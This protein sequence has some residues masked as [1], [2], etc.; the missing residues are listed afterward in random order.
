[1]GGGGWQGW[2]LQYIFQHLIPTHLS[3]QSSALTSQ[4][5]FSKPGKL[6]AQSWAGRECS[7]NFGEGII[8][9][10]LQ[11][12]KLRLTRVRQLS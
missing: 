3:S 8:A 10:I 11:K 1:M 12:K 2:T 6:G 7:T 4:C 9:P 5:S